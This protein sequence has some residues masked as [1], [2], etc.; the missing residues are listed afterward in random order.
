MDW[1]LCDKDSYSSVDYLNAFSSQMLIERKTS[2]LGIVAPTIQSPQLSLE[3]DIG[4]QYGAI[5]CIA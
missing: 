4:L 5:L 2:I 1:P 3:R